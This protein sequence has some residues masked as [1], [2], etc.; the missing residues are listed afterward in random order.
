MR[1]SGPHVTRTH[2]KASGAVTKL[3]INILCI[4]LNSC[5]QRDVV[6]RAGPIISQVP[7][8]LYRKNFFVPQLRAVGIGEHIGSERN[9]GT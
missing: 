5:P 6:N 7:A 9:N 4:L 1:F 2:L 8:R 3:T